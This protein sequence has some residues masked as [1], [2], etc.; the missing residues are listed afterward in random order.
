MRGGLQR[1]RRAPRAAKASRTGS[2]IAR[3]EGVRGA[4]AAAA[5]AARRPAR[6]G[7]RRDRLGRAR[8]DAQSDGRVDR[9]ERE[10]RARGSRPH[11]R[12]RQRHRE[13]GARR[14]DSASA[15]RARRPGPERLVEGEDAGEAGRHVL[16]DA[17]AEHRRGA[18]PPR[19]SKPRQGVLDGEERRLGER[20]SGRARAAVLG[21]R[22]I[23]HPPQVEPEVRR[24]QLRSSGRPR[25][26]KTGSAS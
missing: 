9:R 24:E 15:G 25:A 13:H 26:R 6:V 22:R 23:E 7:Q 19:T 16:A 12:L 1:D 4:Q 20:R 3:V 5:T 21:R 18:R 8:D 14:A 11:L 17:V 10:L 2:I